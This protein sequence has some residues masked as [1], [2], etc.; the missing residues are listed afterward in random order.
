[1]KDEMYKDGVLP[2]NQ[3]CTVFMKPSMDVIDKKFLDMCSDK[4]IN[5]TT[6]S[7]FFSKPIDDVMKKIVK[8]YHPDRR[9]IFIS[10]GLL[11]ELGKI[12]HTIYSETFIFIKTKT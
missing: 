8:K 1:M 9:C 3:C 4:E 5:E 2:Y 10:Q 11:N 6:Y 12:F 7:A